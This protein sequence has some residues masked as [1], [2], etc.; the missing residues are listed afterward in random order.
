MCR[1]RHPDV[2]VETSQC[3][4]R[5]I[6]MFFIKGMDGSEDSRVVFSASHLVFLSFPVEN[7][8]FPVAKPNY[9]VDSLDSPVAGLVLPAANFGSSRL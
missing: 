4:P 6:R 3:L 1:S 9:Q 8:I 5:N 7:L 2:F